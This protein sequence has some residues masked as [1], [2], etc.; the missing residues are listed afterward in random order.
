MMAMS[1]PLCGIRFAR[2]PIM[3]TTSK[4]C[5]YL[6]PSSYSFTR[7]LGLNIESSGRPLRFVPGRL[8][9]RMSLSSWLTRRCGYS[10]LSPSKALL[11]TRSP[12][13]KKVDWRARAAVRRFWGSYSSRPAKSLKPSWP[14]DV[15][16]EPDPVGEALDMV[17]LYHFSRFEVEDEV[18][19]V[20][21]A[22][23]LLLLLPDEEK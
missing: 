2:S 20:L 11:L 3:T 10:T 5:T 19:V 12:V 14:S 18:A 6:P 23:G 8:L 17:E 21:V 7:L 15:D 13:V 22:V 4:R 1:K 9:V 16:E